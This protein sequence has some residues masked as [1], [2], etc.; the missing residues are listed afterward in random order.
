MKKEIDITGVLRVDSSIHRHVWERNKKNYG[1][2]IARKT[3]YI[4]FRRK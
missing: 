3:Y 4:K 2:E 1:S